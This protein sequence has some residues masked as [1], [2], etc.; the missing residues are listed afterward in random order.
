MS[1]PLQVCCNNEPGLR[2]DAFSGKTGGCDATGQ[3][4]G[5]TTTGSTTGEG[6]FRFRLDNEDDTE[7]AVFFLAPPTDR[8][9]GFFALAVAF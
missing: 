5:S 6:F 3:S 1:C 7:V 4:E 9:A 2:A 8:F